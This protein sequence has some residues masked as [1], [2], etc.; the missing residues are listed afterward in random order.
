MGT[1]ESTPLN[2]VLGQFKFEFDVDKFGL[3]RDVDD[4]EVVSAID[5]VLNSPANLSFLY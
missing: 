1:D 3:R 5:I 4:S 2:T